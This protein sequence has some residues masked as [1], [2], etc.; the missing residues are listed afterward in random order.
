MPP[1]P[2]AAPAGSPRK[3]GGAGQSTRDKEAAEVST[4]EDGVTPSQ[5][6]EYRELFNLIDTDSSGEISKDELGN[7]VRILGIKV[8]A[9][10][11]QLM[12]N[13][14]G[15]NNENGEIEFEDF[16]S[17]MTCKISADYTPEEVKK[18]FAMFADGDAKAP[19]GCI[20]LDDLLE[21]VKRY[22]DDRGERNDVVDII[23]RLQTTDNYFN[24][25]NYVAMMMK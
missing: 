16:V 25:E 13:E 17:I 3:K 19:P 10:E 8:S 11:L 20:K 4:R 18:S 6:K 24:F 1:A 7:L 5:L 21:A 14:I 23:A 12:L 15:S 2:A 9:T 22:G